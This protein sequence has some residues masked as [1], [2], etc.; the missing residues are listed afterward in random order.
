MSK[1]GKVSQSP[2]NHGGRFTQDD[3]ARERLKVMRVSPQHDVVARPQEPPKANE[4]PGLQTPEEPV[5]RGGPIT[6][7]ARRKAA[8]SRR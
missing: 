6:A 4:A 3:V 7:T 2:F 8:A 5:K 1:Q